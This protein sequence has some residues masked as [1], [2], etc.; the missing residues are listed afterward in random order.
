MSFMMTTMNTAGTFRLTECTH[1]ID[2]LS[3]IQTSIRPEI[4]EYNVD[5][6]RCHRIVVEFRHTTE[7]IG[8][9][10]AFVALCFATCIAIEFVETLPQGGYLLLR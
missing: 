5:Q 4:I 7:I 8:I 2:K 3:K 10:I 1:K 6:S 9:Q